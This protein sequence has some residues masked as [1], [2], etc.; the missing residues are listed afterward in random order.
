MGIIL[1]DSVLKQFYIL[2]VTVKGIEQDKL[3]DSIFYGNNFMGVRI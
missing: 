2:H 1:S 3:S